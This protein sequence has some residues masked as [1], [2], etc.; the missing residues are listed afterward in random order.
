MMSGA[1]KHQLTGG[2]W[3]YWLTARG[4]SLW[5]TSVFRLNRSILLIEQHTMYS[6]DSLLWNVKYLCTKRNTVH[7]HTGLQ[8]VAVVDGRPQGVGRQPVSQNEAQSNHSEMNALE[9]SQTTTSNTQTHTESERKETLNPNN[10]WGC[11]VRLRSSRKKFWKD[12]IF[13]LTALFSNLL[14]KTLRKRVLSER[15][16]R[17]KNNATHT[18]NKT[19]GSQKSNFRQL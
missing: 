5:S 8:A 18:E 19:L 7:T 1:A 16:S 14:G 15:R 9:N 17:G 12:S 4:S 3:L 10:C 2:W 6:K 11:C 13:L